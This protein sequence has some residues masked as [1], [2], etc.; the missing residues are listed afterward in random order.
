MTQV[1]AS[2][3]IGVFADVSNLYHSAKHLHGAKVNYK[4]LL[5]VAGKD[6]AL[7]RAIAYVVK[8]EEMGES[9]FFEALKQAGWEVK[10]KDLQIFAGGEKKGDWDTGIAIDAIELATKLDVI[11]LLSGDGD[12][13]PLVEHLK[14]AN[15]CKVEVIAFGKSSSGKLREAADEFIDMDK[16]PDK[17][18]IERKKKR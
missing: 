4:E 1:F 13:I 11:V 16:E 14:R 17:F 8:A 9:K 15:A 3:R 6:R 5:K 12:Y 10:S 2:Q 18:L 7:I